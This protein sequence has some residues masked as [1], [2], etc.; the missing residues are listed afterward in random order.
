MS[1]HSNDLYLD[2]RFV[3]AI[4]RI[5]E[6]KNKNP[7][8]LTV[9]DVGSG[10]EKLKE[11]VLDLGMTYY[12][13]DLFPPNDNVRRWDIEQPFPYDGKAH[14]VIMLEVIE[15]LNNP[16]L[17][18]QNIFNVIEEGGHLLLSTPNPSWSGARLYLLKHGVLGMF[19]EQDLELNHHVFTP[20]WHIV[21]YMLQS[22][23]FNNLKR[24]HLGKKTSIVA[25][26]IWGVKLPGRL[27]FRLIKKIIEWS[28]SKAIGALYAIESKK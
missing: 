12:S 27:F 7:H 6:L 19:T 21:R 2:S 13:F 24:Y 4:D 28:D 8:F 17:C 11:A 18:L 15:H 20:W 26:P 10:N 23:G 3:W 25:Y 5:K 16:Y 1:T 14:I 22:V 9:Y